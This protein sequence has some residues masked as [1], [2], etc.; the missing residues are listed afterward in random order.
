MEISVDQDKKKALLKQLAVWRLSDWSN[1]WF[2]AGKSAAQKL[3][4]SQC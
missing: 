2:T 1:I 3:L 4:R